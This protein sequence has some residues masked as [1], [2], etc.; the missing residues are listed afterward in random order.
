ML[1]AA[2]STCNIVTRQL[3]RSASAPL[4]CLRHW[5]HSCRRAARARRRA[6][7]AMPDGRRLTRA[8]NP[9]VSAS[10]ARHPPYLGV[11]GS[12]ILGLTG[13]TKFAPLCQTIDFKGEVYEW[14]NH[15]GPGGA[16]TKK[17]RNPL[18]VTSLNVTQQMPS[19]RI[20]RFDSLV[21]NFSNCFCYCSKRKRK[22]EGDSEES[23]VLGKHDDRDGRSRRR[24]R[25][26]RRAQT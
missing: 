21:T 26:R 8:H 15:P 12:M 3:R 13:L 9:A 23:W 1:V 4:R 2:V 7:R 24:R 11:K 17:N 14:Q 5:R 18:N 16:Q 10:P 19:F 22:R 6:A 25:R 20:Q